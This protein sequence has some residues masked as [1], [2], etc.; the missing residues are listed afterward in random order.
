VL[1]CSGSIG[2]DAPPAP[3]ETV[4][5]VVGLPTSPRYE[6][7]QTSRSGSGAERLFAKTGLVIKAGSAFDL[8]VPAGT[9]LRIGWGQTDPGTR[10]HVP[11]CPNAGGD[12]WLAYPGG[13][14]TTRPACVPLVVAAAGGRREVHIGLGTPCPGQ[15][16]PQGPSD[17]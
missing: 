17:R 2:T 6:A 15:R 7:L 9:A 16:P 14:W 3:F 11:A 8:I 5:G 10:L 1:S 12:G 13:Y 4:L